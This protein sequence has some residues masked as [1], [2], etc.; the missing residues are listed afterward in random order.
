MLTEHLPILHCHVNDDLVGRD[1]LLQVL[2]LASG[3]WSNHWEVPGLLLQHYSG[4]SLLHL[5]IRIWNG[6]TEKRE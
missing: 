4:P 5:K 1:V 6:K 2:L 3:Y